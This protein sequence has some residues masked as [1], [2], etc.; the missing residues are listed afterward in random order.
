MGRELNRMNCQQKRI[1]KPSPLPGAIAWISVRTF[2]LACALPL[3]ILALPAWAVSL[4][5]LLL[6]IFLLLDHA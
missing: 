5:A 1:G 6:P 4:I 2:A 3:L